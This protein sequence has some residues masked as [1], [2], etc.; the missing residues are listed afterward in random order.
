MKNN[1]IDLD[2]LSCMFLLGILV[3]PIMFALIIYQPKP[4]DDY[5]ED[6]EIIIEETEKIEV[7]KTDIEILEEPNIN[8]EE[9][10]EEE[11]TE[12]RK[13]DPADFIT[14]EKYLTY[15]E[16]EVISNIIVF[17]V[18]YDGSLSKLD[19][20]NNINSLSIKLKNFYYAEQTYESVR[21]MVVKAGK[22]EDLVIYACENGVSIFSNM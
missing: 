7:V 21:I 16:S 9:I 3:I 8:K 18:I 20:E 19:L 2:I 11:I 5:E 12:E 10:T 1:K 22:N 4:M 6:T 13:L 17:T 14:A 15:K